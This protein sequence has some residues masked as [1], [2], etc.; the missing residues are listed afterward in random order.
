M[1]MQGSWTYSVTGQTVWL[2]NGGCH[3]AAAST[4]LELQLQIQ[5]QSSPFLCEWMP[6]CSRLCV[7]LATNNYKAKVTACGAGIGQQAGHQSMATGWSTEASYQTPGIRETLLQEYGLGV[8]RKRKALERQEGSRRGK[9]VMQSHGEWQ[10]PRT[11]TLVQLSQCRDPT[12]PRRRRDK[13]EANIDTFD[14]RLQASQGR[15][16]RVTLA[17]SSRR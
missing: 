8:R 15:G 5:S 17:E 13:V 9:A 11:A 7:S 14:D 10:L 16:V 3:A 12:C 1:Q 4:P 2:V 6:G